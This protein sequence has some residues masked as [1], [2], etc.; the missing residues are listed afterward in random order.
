[1]LFNTY[2]LK[3]LTWKILLSLVVRCYNFSKLLGM[4]VNIFLKP[5]VQQNINMSISLIRFHYEKVYFVLLEI[6]Y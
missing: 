1:M 4:Y 2:F 3:N 5:F 6:T